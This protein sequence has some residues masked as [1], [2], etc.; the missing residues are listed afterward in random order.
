MRHRL[1]KNSF[2]RPA[3]L[4]PVLCL[5]LL[6]GCGRGRTVS[7]SC[8][9]KEDTEFGA[10][11]TAFSREQFDAFGFAPG[12]SVDVAFEGGPDLTDVPYFTG[13]YVRTGCHVVVAYPG[14]PFVSVTASNTGIWKQENLREGQGITITLR[15]KGKYLS[16]QETMSQTYSFDRADYESDEQ[17]AN[18][19]GLSGG[20][21]KEG[22]VYRGASPV[23]DSRGRAATVSALLER[24]GIGFVLDLADT[25]ETLAAKTAEAD[26]RSEELKVLYE[27]GRVSLL[28]LNADYTADAYRQKL[29]AGLT[30]AAAS[31]GPI[32]VH[33]LEGKD[34]TGFVCLLLEALAGA[35]CDELLADYM[36]TYRNYYGIT[37]EDTPEKYNAVKDVYFGAFCEFL[38][39]T[40]D[41]AALRAMDLSAAAEDYLLS[42]G[43]TE[44]TL[45]ALLDR[46]T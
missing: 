37:A 23:D 20:S 42:A 39:G 29:A 44:E 1:T 24:Y 25:E 43:M 11:L 32:Y 17:F 7:A 33:C 5:M 10:A 21:L 12:D 26:Y 30:A 38:W 14:D 4:L 9:V 18:L 13:Y 19:R 15:E 16:A 3:A 40:V 31:E 35:D 27:E 8:A 45:A 34:R 36:L 28:G 2:I 41:L 46:I 22:A 6:C